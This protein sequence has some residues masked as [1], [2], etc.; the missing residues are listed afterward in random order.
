LIDITKPLYTVAGSYR[1]E[2]ISTAGREPYVLIGYVGNEYDNSLYAWTRDGKNFEGC[3][4]GFDLINYD[5]GFEPVNTAQRFKKLDTTGQPLPDDATD[6]VGVLD[7]TTNLI[8]SRDTLPCGEVNHADA[9]EVASEFVLCGAPARLP[10]RI[11][12]LSLVDDA[13]HA[14][15]IDPIFTSESDWYWASTPWARSPSDCA[16]IVSFAYGYS[17]YCYR[18]SKC[19][20]RAC[21]PSE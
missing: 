21:R 11:E 5:E 14:P 18:N 16:W 19:F 2:L 8:W 7:T 15:A 17:D 3:E 20:V 1:V 9:V 4:S 10:T 12:L 6:Y 13:R